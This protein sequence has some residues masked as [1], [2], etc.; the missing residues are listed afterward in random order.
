M[1]AGRIGPSR[2]PRVWDRC[3]RTTFFPPLLIKVMINNS[4][5]VVSIPRREQEPELEVIIDGASSRFVVV[6]SNLGFS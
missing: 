4:S 5:S 2:G 6:N 1:L 3:S